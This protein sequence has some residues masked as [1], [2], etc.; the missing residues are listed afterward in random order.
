MPDADQILRLPLLPLLAAQAVWVRAR[1][2]FLPEPDGPRAGRAGVGRPLRLLIAGDSAGAGVGAD[3]QEEALSGRLVAALAGR[4]DVHWRLEATTGHTTRDTI[5]VL[6]AL[7]PEPFDVAVL[8]LGVN[9]VTRMTTRAQW[10]ARRRALHDLLRRKF[11]VRRI[12]ASGLPP[13][14]RFPLL[15]QPLRWVLG[16]QAARLDAA[17]AELAQEA[18]DL[19]HVPLDLPYEPRF[20]AADGYHP[21]P[22]A[23][24]EWARLLAD[25]IDPHQARTRSDLGS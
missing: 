11:G 17:L 21:S 16:R 24:V 22:A 12:I 9:D 18:P 15:P 14:G 7:P 1:A 2:E 5:A 4:H 20:V 13:M 10:V 6:E 19:V 3:R 23:F 8:S 25:R